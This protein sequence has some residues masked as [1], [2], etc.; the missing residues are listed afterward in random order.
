[1]SR[2]AK[3]PIVLPQGVAVDLSSDRI[4][5]KG[6]LGALAFASHPAVTV[7]LEDG[8]LLCKPVVRS[9]RV[10]RHVR[11]DA[12]CRRQYGDRGERRVRAQVEVSLASAIVPRCRVTRLI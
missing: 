6:P 7:T 5:V 4:S 1:M 8:S 2:V 9:G 10:S 11:H 3:K 12:R